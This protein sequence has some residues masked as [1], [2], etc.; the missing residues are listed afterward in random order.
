MIVLSN[1][2]KISISLN[3]FSISYRDLP[4]PSSICSTQ[5]EKLC[6][7]PDQSLIVII[8]SILMVVDEVSALFLQQFTPLQLFTGG[9]HSLQYVRVIQIDTNIGTVDN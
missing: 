2:H 7:Q 5:Q 6:S 9:K 1:Q 3:S 8:V 4:K